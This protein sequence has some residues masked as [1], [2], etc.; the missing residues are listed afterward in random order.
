MRRPSEAGHEAPRATCVSGS[1]DLARTGA[2]WVG[3][4]FVGGKR[5]A[6]RSAT[7]REAR[8]RGRGLRPQK[9]K[10]GLFRLRCSTRRDADGGHCDSKEESSGFDAT[11]GR[12]RLGSYHARSWSAGTALQSEVAVRPAT[13]RWWA[14][15]SLPNSKVDLHAPP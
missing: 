6:G 1:G 14:P 2:G 4:G 5:G 15:G 3:T 12:D 13:A 10:W 8:D 7:A 11:H 9:W